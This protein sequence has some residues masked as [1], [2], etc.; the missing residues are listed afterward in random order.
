[1]RGLLRPGCSPP[2]SG[3]HRRRV[4][5]FSRNRAGAAY[6]VGHMA[7]QEAV[8]TAY[9]YAWW[10][11][12]E[13]RTAE[14]AVRTAVLRHRATK[15]PQRLE[16]LL[17]EVRNLAVSGPTMSPA[18]E[19]ALLH[20]HLGTELDVAAR[21]AEI[22][23]AEA[24]EALARGRL[25]ALERRVEE[26]FEHPD[27]LGGLAVGNPGDINHAR[28]CD[29][30]AHARQLLVAGRR[31]LHDLPAPTIPDTL[32]DLSP[33][34]AEVAPAAAPP[35]T[36]AAATTEPE[37]DRAPAPIRITTAPPAPERPR[38]PEEVE[39]ERANRVWL[40]VAV[41]TV[42]TIVFFVVP[43]A[44]FRLSDQP[45]ETASPPSPSPQV[46]PEEPA[47]TEPEEPAETEPEEPAETEPEPE[48]PD[49]ADAPG[50]EEDE[51]AFRI[52]RTGVVTPGN[53]TPASGVNVDA[54]E[55][56]RIVVEYLGAVEGV[57]LVARWT[58]DGEPFEEFEVVLTSRR[59]SHGFSAPRPPEGWPEG[60]HQVLLVTDGAIVAAV[61]FSVG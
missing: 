29:S 52:V 56:L 39:A 17:R 10:L 21:L 54:Q 2:R 7:A 1:V 60:T 47:E 33:G 49:P 26:P 16:A 5:R 23:L 22:A 14:D 46:E 8:V 57:P 55:P 19:L 4:G 42:L 15:D 50:L 31:E 30:C 36:E 37:A 13:D 18:A 20:D 35:A 58:V 45:Q 28:Q 41:V 12:G 53:D 38:T 9:T 24:R 44:G 51:D 40:W 27:R 6:G 32:A 43:L 48:G 11:S 59:G 34:M 3:S 25:E 61:D